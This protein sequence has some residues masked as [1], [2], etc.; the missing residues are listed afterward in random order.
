MAGIPEAF[1]ARIASLPTMPDAADRVLRLLKEPHTTAES[2]RRV[3]EIDPSLTAAVLRLANSSLFGP[4]QKTANLSHAIMLIGFFRL[5]S[6]TLTTVVAGLRSL[7][8]S[9]AAG[10]RELIWAHSVNTGLAARA[11]AGRLGAAWGEEAFV[12]GLMHDC[13]R[14][15]LLAVE[16]ESY[17]QLIEQSGGELPASAEERAALGLCHQQTGGALMRQWKMAGQLVRVVETHHEP[18]RTEDEDALLTAVVMLAD[19]IQYRI[20]GEDVAQPAELLGLDL[21]TLPALCE[22]IRQE[23]AE[24]RSVL[25]AM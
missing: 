20:R 4:P 11:L 1:A 7:I 19:R 16:T 6:L 22:E 13:G 25:M 18:L 3:I 24:A 5:R 17:Q 12:A 9:G 23:V 14:L 10:E 15:V 2:L 21:E 8:P